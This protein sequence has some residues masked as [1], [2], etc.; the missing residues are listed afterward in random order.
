MVH[1]S[2][3]ILSAGRP[4]RIRTPRT[5]CRASKFASRC[6]TA[7]SFIEWVGFRYCADKALR[8]TAAAVYWRMLRRIDHQRLWMSA[9]IERLHRDHP[10]LPFRRARARPRASSRTARVSS[11]RT[12]RSSKGHDRFDRLP[13][14]AERPFRPLHRDS[15]GFPSPSE[16]FDRLGVL[17]WFRSDGAEGEGSN[18]KRYCVEKEALDLPTLA[19]RV[20][21]RRPAGVQDVFDLS[22]DDLHAIRRGRRLRPQLH[23]E[24]RSAARSR[25][26]RNQGSRPRRRGRA[27]RESQL[28][29]PHPSAGARGVSRVAAARGRVRARRQRRPRPRPASR[30]GPAATGSRSS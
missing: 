23:R 20:I 16:L 22:V 9:R 25:R 7:L 6:P 13:T 18:A 1:A 14:P 12:T 24:Q 17:H 11:F 15:C 27:L 28:R 19:L 4:R 10:E 3:S 2:T 30:S 5:V 26:R 29:G 8:A 21:D